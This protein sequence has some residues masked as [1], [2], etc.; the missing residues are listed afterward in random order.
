[1]Y[2]KKLVLRNTGPIENIEYTFPFVGELPKPVVFVGA[3]GSGKSI[4][5]SHLLNP[6]MTA[7]Q[8]AF[9]DTE[10]EKERVFKLRSPQYIRIGANFSYSQLVFGD[11]FKCEEWQ[12]NQSREAFEKVSVIP[13]DASYNQILPNEAS[14]FLPD[15]E[16]RV[17]DVTEQFQRNCVLYFPANRFEQPAWLNERNLSAT[18]SFAANTRMSR[19]SNRKII[20]DA[21]LSTSKN[22]IMDVFLDRAIYGIRTQRVSAWSE[23]GFIDVT[24]LLPYAG[25]ASAIW[26]EINRLVRL[27]VSTDKNVRL[28]IGERGS[29]RI[30]IVG[31]SGSD[32][33]PNI[34]QL[35]TGQTSL[36]NIFL[37]IVRDFDCSGANFTTFSEVTGLVII[38]EVDA[39]LHCSLQSVLLPSLIKMFPKVQ[40]ILTTHSPLFLLGMKTHFGEQGFDLRTLPTGEPV[41][42][43]EFEEFRA[44]YDHFAETDA[45]RQR[46]EKEVNAS[47]KPV[48]FVEGDLDIRYLQRAASLLSRVSILQNISLYDGE[49]YGGLDKIWT[50]LESRITM[51]LPRIAGLIYDC[52][53]K[54]KDKVNDRENHKAKRK[55]I[56]Q[57]SA[58]PISKGIE[59]LFPPQTIAV[60][61]SSHPQFFDITPPMVRTER[62]VPVEQREVCEINKAE[63]KN[64]CDWLCQNGT[65]ED[66]VNFE[67][68]FEMI[69]EIAPSIADVPQSTTTDV[70]NPTYTGEVSPKHLEQMGTSFDTTTIISEKLAEI[71]GYSIDASPSSFD[72]SNQ[73]NS[74]QQNLTID[75]PINE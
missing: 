51:A 56:Q 61:R 50:S 16:G 48:I 70:Q 69:V 36:L 10:V 64:M 1:M 67:R 9:D 17:S 11:N 41:A 44:A 38:D 54:K 2:L 15:F 57:L 35:S 37:S 33:V 5:L 27:I 60:L 59:N 73:D 62:G 71:S 13:L 52:D 43:E 68:V 25:S 32:T 53:T 66:F 58:N 31:G 72:S 8:V 4:L 39:H 14:L 40:F 12:L 74:A 29:R 24:Q 23:N 75:T 49:G 3:N 7:Q 34:F 47:Q 42:V 19:Q 63:K 45:F 28:G 65:R 22:W 46:L 18:A 26:D 55:M 30:S 21:P 6:L 20:Q